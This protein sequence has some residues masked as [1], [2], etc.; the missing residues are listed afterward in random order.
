MY[1]IIYILF[2]L[3]YIMEPPSYMRSV[4]DCD[5][6]IRR[7]SV[8]R[9]YDT[10]ISFKCPAHRY[11]YVCFFLLSCLP[12]PFLSLRRH[13]FIYTSLPSLFLVSFPGD[14]L[15]PS[16]AVPL[17]PRPITTPDLRGPRHTMASSVRSL[18][19]VCFIPTF[20]LQVLNIF[21]RGTILYFVTLFRVLSTIT[22]DKYVKH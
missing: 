20:Y 10:Y 9:S 11:V 1:H 2:I 22:S 8:Q 15:S 21:T 18:A 4:F 17:S 14:G 3:Y 13:L 6:I 7:T 5:V 12:T 16:P 19:S